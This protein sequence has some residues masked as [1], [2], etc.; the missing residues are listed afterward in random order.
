[1]QSLSKCLVTIATTSPVIDLSPIVSKAITIMVIVGIIK[2][3]ILILR[4]KA[5]GAFGEGLV[6]FSARINL[7]SRKYHLI[8]N[9]T[10]PTSRGTTQIDHIFV[11]VYGVFIVETKNGKGKNVKSPFYTNSSHLPVNYTEDVF[12]VLELQ[13]NLQ[14]KYTGGTV[15]HFFLGERIEDT[16]SVKNLVK[17]I[18]ENYRLPY[19]TLSPTFSVCPNHGYI[20]GEVPVCDKCQSQCEVYSRIVGYLRPVNQWNDGKKAEFD[21]RKTYKAEI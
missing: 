14:T 12:E 15:L 7:D 21:M 3:A 6:N 8:K 17:K 16:A 11:S 9:V 4:P 2:I 20:P 18:C 19:F 5:K 13:D 1:M 10:L